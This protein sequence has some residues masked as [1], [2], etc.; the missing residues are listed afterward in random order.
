MERKKACL[1]SLFKRLTSGFRKEDVDHLTSLQGA[2]ELCHLLLASP[3]DQARTLTASP[4]DLANYLGWKTGGYEVHF[5]R[6]PSTPKET[7]PAPGKEDAMQEDGAAEVKEEEAQE[8]AGEAAGAAPEV[9]EEEGKGEVLGRKEEGRKEEEAPQERVHP[10]VLLEKQVVVSQECIVCLC[11][12]LCLFLSLSTYVYLCLSPYLSLSISQSLYLCLH[13]YLSSS[14]S[15]D[16][17][18]YFSVSVYQ[19]LYLCISLSQIISSSI[20][21]LAELIQVQDGSL[22]L[23]SLSRLKG[24]K[25]S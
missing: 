24:A 5:T 19:F 6:T 13:F 25:R 17:S 8:E 18:L 7:R 3:P 4:Q 11:V 1:I 14:L 9:K 2:V 22:Y 23:H 21:D 12:Y 15:L 16:L 10:L 20:T